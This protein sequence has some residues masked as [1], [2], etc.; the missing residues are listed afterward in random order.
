MVAQTIG[1]TGQR[2]SA[3]RRLFTSGRWIQWFV[4]LLLAT[5]SLAMFYPFLWL[6]FSSFKTGADI[7]SVPVSLLPR[8]WTLSAYRMVLDPNRAN[9]PR[10]YVNSIVVAT[11]TVVAILATSSLG[12]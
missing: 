2:Q 6:I 5:F 12:G 9:L 11:A 8:E 10:A 1:R 7:V 4:G 3:V